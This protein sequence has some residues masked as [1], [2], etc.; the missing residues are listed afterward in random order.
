[1]LQFLCQWFW[2]PRMELHVQAFV[3]S[4]RICAQCKDPR[5]RPAGLLHPLAVPSRPWSHLSLDFVTGLPPLSRGNTVILVV[6]DRFSKAGHFVALSKLPSAKKN[7]K[8]LLTQ[9]VRIHGLPSDIVSARRPQFTSW[10]WGAF[11][12]LL[13]EEASLSSGLHLQSN[14]QTE[15]VN[16]D[17][18]LILR[19]LAF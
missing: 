10:F 18:E 15:R 2:W 7:A 8:L 12:R 19:C 6:I 4:C 13:G 3:N 16:Q 1:M 14:G 11:C 17:L 9:V 5:T